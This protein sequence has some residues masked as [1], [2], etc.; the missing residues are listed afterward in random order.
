MPI[1]AVLCAMFMRYALSRTINELEYFTGKDIYI[2]LAGF[3]GIRLAYSKIDNSFKFVNSNT[4]PTT[5]AYDDRA[6]LAMNGNKFELFIGGVQ[7]CQQKNLIVRC[8][9]SDPKKSSLFKISKDQFGFELSNGDMCI[10]KDMDAKGEHEEVRAA[11]G[12]DL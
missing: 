5:F 7:A 2:K 9:S 6:R 11:A 10:T 12:P 1:Y 4:N 3:D 8:D